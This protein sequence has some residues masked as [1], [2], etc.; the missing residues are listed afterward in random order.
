MIRQMLSGQHYPTVKKKKKRS[1]VPLFSLQVVATGVC[2]TDLY[3]LFE[4]MHKDGFPVVLGHEG[5]GIIESVGPGVTEFQPGQ[6]KITSSK[7]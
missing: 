4:G 1:M 3:H 2:H 5:A 6:F 7:F